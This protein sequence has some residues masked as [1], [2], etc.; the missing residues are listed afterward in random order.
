LAPQAAFNSYDKQH[1]PSKKLSHEDY[2]VGWICP[3]EVEQTAALEMLDKGNDR[4]PQSPA[5]HNV[6]NLGS[7]ANQ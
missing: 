4:L 1:S 7:I 5:D 2:T 6:Y 3:L